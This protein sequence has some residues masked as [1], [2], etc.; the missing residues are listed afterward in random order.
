MAS[1]HVWPQVGL[2]QALL[3]YLDALPFDQCLEI[4]TL[5]EIARMVGRPLPATARRTAFWHSG[6]TARRN[7]LRHGFTAFVGPQGLVVFHRI[8]HRREPLSSEHSW[9]RGV[10]DEPWLCRLCGLQQ[11]ACPHPSWRQAATGAG[12]VCDWCGAESD[13]ARDETG[14][15]EE[16]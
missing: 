7:W 6:D 9:E 10:E 13:T 3:N 8:N 15:V 14:V 12:S 1:T 4:L 2:Y 5:D 11:R 16:R